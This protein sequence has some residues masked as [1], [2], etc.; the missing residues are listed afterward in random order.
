[1]NLIKFCAGVWLVTQAVGILAA[2]FVIGMLILGACGCSE[3]KIIGVYVGPEFNKCRAMATQDL[4]KNLELTYCD[5][6]ELADKQS[7][8]QVHAWVE[9]SVFDSNFY[10]YS[11][12]SKKDIE[13][14]G[15]LCKDGGE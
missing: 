5:G 12:V 15:I 14:N 2:L 11:E 3:P 9:K 7:G 8:I 1:M 6:K 4:I 10:C 13:K